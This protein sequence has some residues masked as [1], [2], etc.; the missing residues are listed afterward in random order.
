[1]RRKHR[2]PEN[3]GHC[4]G[5][6]HRFARKFVSRLLQP[7]DLPEVAFPL[8]MI[9]SHHDAMSQDELADTH[10]IDKSTV[11]RA[12]TRMEDAELVSRSV[13]PGDR[14]VK[15]VEITERGAELADQLRE[16]LDTW[17]ERLLQHLARN[18][19]R[20]WDDLASGAAGEIHPR[21]DS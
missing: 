16:V 1:M 3:V 4:V 5:M 19:H 21:G 18:A 8:M 13:D 11:A 12:L 15:R 9:L 6:I 2:H 17:N 7:L 14:R 10:L 20:H